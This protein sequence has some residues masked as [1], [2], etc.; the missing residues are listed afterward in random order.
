MANEKYNRW[1]NYETWRINLE[2]IDDAM[3][4]L[5]YVAMEKLTE[6]LN[7]C[8]DSWEADDVDFLLETNENWDVLDPDQVKQLENILVTIINQRE[9]CAGNRMQKIGLK[10]ISN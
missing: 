1:A 4:S 6:L 2:I 10:K 3:D 9:G 5:R 8:D 7:D